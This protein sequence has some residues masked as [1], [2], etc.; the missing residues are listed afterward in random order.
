MTWTLSAFADEAGGST[1]D[2]IAALKKGGLTHIDLRGVDGHNISVIPLDAAQ[3]AAK[4]LQAAGVTVAMFG[5]PIGKI[6]IADDVKADLD[7]LDHLG[8][9][10]DVFGCNAVRIFSYYNKGNADKKKWKAEALDRLNR[11]KERA[12]KHGLVLYHENESHIF[13][14]HPDDVA[15]LIP[16]R[17][18]QTFKLIYDFAN[19][20]RTGVEGW[21]IWQ[22]F[23]GATDCFHF[24]DQKRGGEH[25]PMGQGDTDAARI[26]A[27]AAKSGWSG[28]VTIEPHLTHSKA[29][30]VT[31]VEGTGNK[32]LA[33]MTPAQTFQVAVEGAKNVLQQ[34]GVR[35]V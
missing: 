17:D 18:R 25:V 28:P 12:S 33:D 7:K 6:D 19:Y 15:E 9:L 4:K 23:R 22:T 26:V 29:V 5:S 11:L 20:N 13:G 30:V 21:K 3:G 16:L 2:Q 14:D 24:K 10:K 1:D 35:F 27:D 32:A 34:A 8:R 31:N